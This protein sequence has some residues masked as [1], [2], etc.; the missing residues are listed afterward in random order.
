MN[1]TERIGSLHPGGGLAIGGFPSRPM[2]TYVSHMFI[3]PTPTHTYAMYIRY[4]YM[5]T[6]ISYMFTHTHT[7]TLYISLSLPHLSSFRG[8]LTMHTVLTSLSTVC[9]LP[10]YGV[11]HSVPC[12]S[13]V[14]TQ[15]P[16]LSHSAVPER[17]RE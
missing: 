7:H 11:R 15:S 8:S 13:C 12:Q 4:L 16:T 2:Q 5:Y 14:S 1:A 3:H 9:F 17:V 6:H 10:H